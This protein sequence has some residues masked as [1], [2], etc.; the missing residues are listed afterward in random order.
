VD[1]HCVTGPKLGHSHFQ[2]LSFK[3]IDDVHLNLP[4]SFKVSP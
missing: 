3:L 2:L 1:A 4:S